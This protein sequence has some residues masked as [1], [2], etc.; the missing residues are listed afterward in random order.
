VAFRRTSY[1]DGH[2]SAKNEG[3][4]FYWSEEKLIFLRAREQVRRKNEQRKEQ[5]GKEFRAAIERRHAEQLAATKQFFR[6]RLPIIGLRLTWSQSEGNLIT[7]SDQQRLFQWTG[8]VPEGQKAVW[9]TLAARLQTESEEYYKDRPVRCS[10]VYCTGTSC[11]WVN[12]G[13]QHYA[14]DEEALWDCLRTVL[15]DRAYD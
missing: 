7:V 10:M 13:D 3:E 15:Y 11:G 4:V 12:C 6:G 5:E 8:P 2:Y 14:S 1:V 9:A